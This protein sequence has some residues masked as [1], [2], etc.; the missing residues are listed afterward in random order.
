LPLDIEYT[1]AEMQLVPYARSGLFVDFPVTRSF[2]ALIT[3]ELKDG[4]FVPIGAE[5]IIN[6]QKEKFVVGKRGEVYIKNLSATNHI[7]AVWDSNK[8]EFDLSIDLKQTNE[9]NIGSVKCLN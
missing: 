8:C 9:Q 7:I 1:A 4:T 5:V 2:N 3:L 6:D